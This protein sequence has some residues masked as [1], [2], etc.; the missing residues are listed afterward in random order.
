MSIGKNELRSR[1]WSEWVEGLKNLRDSLRNDGGQIADLVC[2]SMSGDE[3]FVQR[4]AINTQRNMYLGKFVDYKTR[5]AAY[6][7]TILELLGEVNATLSDK[8]EYKNARVDIQIVSDSELSNDDWCCQMI[9]AYDKLGK[10]ADAIIDTL[11]R[12][13]EVLNDKGL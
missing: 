1:L 13:Q 2:T 3:N 10:S 11:N 5:I 4:A 6:E 7:T 8:I 9:D 12:V